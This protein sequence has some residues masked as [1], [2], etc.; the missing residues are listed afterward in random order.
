MAEER[1]GDRAPS[2]AGGG[3]PCG[4]GVRGTDGDLAEGDL[5]PGSK[6]IIELMI[7]QEKV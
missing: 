7:R 2:G 6:K 4:G 3:R 1:T 5:A